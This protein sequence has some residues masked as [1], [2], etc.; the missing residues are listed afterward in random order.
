PGLVS[1]MAMMHKEHGILP[2][3]R[4]FDPAIRLATEG[5]AVSPRLHRLVSGSRGLQTSPLAAQYFFDENGDPLPVGHI[6][7]NPQYARV[8]QRLAEQGAASFYEGP[9]ARDMVDAVQRHPVPGD[10]SERDL[11]EYQAIRRDA[12]CTV[13]GVYRYCGMPP[14]SSGGLAV[15]Q[16]MALLEH[17]PIRNLRPNSAEAVHY[18]S[19]AGRLAFADRDAYVADPAFVRVPVFGLLD[20]DYL[21]ARSQ[22]IQPHRSMQ[23]AEAGVP[24]GLIES[25]PADAALEQPATTHL[26]AADRE[27]NVVTM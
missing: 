9:L 20:P 16:M 17:T 13:V 12:L 25:P 1:M 10:L 7:R 26:V 8:L 6:L 27:G 3:Q 22:L 23:R 21:A 15:I 4:L 14:P 24:A 2:W 5:F 19:E 11:A 18:F